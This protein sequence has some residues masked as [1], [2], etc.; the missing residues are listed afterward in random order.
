MVHRGRMVIGIVRIVV[1]SLVHVLRRSTA[2]GITPSQGV[3][4]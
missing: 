4:P 1:A 2:I 3:T